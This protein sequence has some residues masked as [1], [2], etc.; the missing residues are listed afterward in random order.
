MTNVNLE[1]EE[2]LPF[3]TDSGTG[4]EEEDTTGEELIIK[5]FDAS[6]I[7]VTTKFLTLGQLLDR[8]RDKGIDLSPDFQRSFVWKPAAQSRLIESTFIRFPLPAFYMDATDDDK[9]LV[10]DGLQRLTTLKKFVLDKKLR[11]IDLEFLGDQ[12]DKKTYDELPASLKRRINETQVTVYLIEK[13]TPPDV[14]F[15]IFKRIN[16]GGEPLS[17]QEIRH[18]LNQGEVTKLLKRLAESDEFQK[19]INYGV[20]DNRMGDREMVLRFLVFAKNSYTTYQKPDLD[21]FLNQN[22]AELNLL[23]QAELE[24]LAQRFFRAMRAAH[25]IFGTNA[26]RKYNP[27]KNR[28]LFINKALF[29][30]WAVNLDKLTDDQLSLLA[31]RRDMLET[32]F[33]KLL[34]DPEF[35]KVISQGTGDV[36]KVRARFDRIEALIKEVLV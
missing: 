13:G 18:A 25:N 16:T 23:P 24:G 27:Q 11:L 20:R 10:V 31:Q 4:I 26:F 15:N 17:P 5:P 12:Y 6:L 14:K 21:G 22:M 1:Q 35:D 3:V 28:W 19:T 34:N 2:F 29:E 30:T 32:K 36:S 8:I 9:W 33:I 7:R